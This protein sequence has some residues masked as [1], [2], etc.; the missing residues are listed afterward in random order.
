M[1][2]IAYGNVQFVRGNDPQLGIAKFPPVLMPNHGDLY[3]AG[4]L[5]SILNGMDDSG[6]GQEQHDDDQDWNDCPGQLNLRAP[7]YLSRLAAGIYGSPTE[8][9]DGIAE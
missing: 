4:R 1:I 5:W 2:R 6:S 9:D 3:S 8:L 7:I